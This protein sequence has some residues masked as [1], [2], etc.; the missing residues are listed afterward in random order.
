MM[1]RIKAFLLKHQKIN[2]IVA[3]I[4]RFVFGGRKRIRGK[5]NEIMYAN[6][7]MKR[8]RIQITGSGNRV[9]FQGTNYLEGCTFHITGDHN[10]IRLD[11]QVCAYGGVFCIEDHGG[12]IQVGRKTLFSGQIELA[13]TEGT[14]I[15]VGEDCLFSSQIDIRSGDS[16]SIFDETGKRINPAADITIGNHVWIGRVS[17][18]K[19]TYIP[20][21]CVVGTGAILT[22]AYDTPNACIVGVPAKIV[23]EQIH[24]THER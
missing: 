4:Y 1:H 22:K 2:R 3:R 16:H 5:Q 8:C 11:D 12:C 13:S 24:W 9:I 23:K 17:V 15:S 20:A 10:E 18:L 6:T 19:G 14:T 21:G 7:Y